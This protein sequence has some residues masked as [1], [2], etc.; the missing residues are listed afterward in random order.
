MLDIQLLAKVTFFWDKITFLCRQLRE[1][2]A[3]K[4]DISAHLS[5]ITV[6][7]NADK[8]PVNRNLANSKPDESAISSESKKKNTKEKSNTETT[9]NSNA[10]NNVERQKRETEKKS[11]SD[12]R[13]II[14]TENNGKRNQ[15]KSQK[16]MILGDS[17]I[18]N[19]KGW[20]ISK[21]LHYVN[22]YVR[23]F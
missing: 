9:V 20:E 21:K 16:I 18:K 1:D 6:A 15:N 19:I 23:H 12:S 7:G 2:V 5:N 13:I 17:M 8:A 3:K 14:Q 4:V 10:N 22:V 11:K